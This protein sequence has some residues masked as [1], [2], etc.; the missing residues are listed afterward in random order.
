MS[1]DNYSIAVLIPCY[2]EELTIAEVI[3][4]FREQLPHATLYVYDNNSI[5]RTAE[6][7]RKCGA[8]VRHEPQQGKGHVIRRM[9]ADIDSDIFIMVD[10]DSTYP[11]Q[12]VTKMVET[13]VSRKLDM[14][15]GV[16]VGDKDAYRG[17]HAEGNRLFNKMVAFLFGRGMTD[18]FSGYRVFS[19]RFVKSFPALSRGFDIETEL[20]VHALELYLP[21]A[22]LPVQY[23]SRPKGSF[24]KLSTYKDGFKIL[25]RIISL[26]KEAK[27]FKLFMLIACLLFL[28]SLVLGY[29]LVITWLHTGLVPRFPTAFIVVGL[30]IFSVIAF[31][32]GVILDGIAQ[33]R[34]EN[35][36]LHYLKLAAL[37]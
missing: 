14:V 37:P 27:P 34:L 22:E 23:K 2:N 28:A 9:F 10:G 3:T 26:F 20:S 19:R 24:S 4:S 29:P 8:I 15:T 11:A 33:L 32:S 31:T 36:R 18:I 21:F 30:L 7:A 17:Y 35:K 1:Y 16:R 12:D 13:L 6:I 5:D 25:G